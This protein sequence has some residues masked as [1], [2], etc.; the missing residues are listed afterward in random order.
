[1]SKY[2]PPGEVAIDEVYQE[3]YTSYTEEYGANGAIGNWE[4]GILPHYAEEFEY[5]IVIGS[6]DRDPGMT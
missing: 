6:A 3:D 2:A 4:L 1:M 5:T